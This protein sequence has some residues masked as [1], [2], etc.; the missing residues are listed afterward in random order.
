MASR[1]SAL[2]PLAGATAAAVALAGVAVF[3]VSQASCADPGRYVRHDDGQVE[4]VGSCVDTDKLPAAPDHGDSDRQP[5]EPASNPMDPAL[6][7][8]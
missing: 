2:L 1:V 8:P 6:R 7:A 3:S 5:A 4:L